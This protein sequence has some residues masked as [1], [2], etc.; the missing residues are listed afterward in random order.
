MLQFACAYWSIVSSKSVKAL[1]RLE[2]M[3]QPDVFNCSGFFD[4]RNFEEDNHVRSLVP[5]FF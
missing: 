3:I 1:Q 4:E 2:K 5:V